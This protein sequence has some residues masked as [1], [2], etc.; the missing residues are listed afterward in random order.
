MGPA[1]RQV[2]IRQAGVGYNAGLQSQTDHTARGDGQRVQGRDRAC[3]LSSLPF[4]SAVRAFGSMRTRLR[5]WLLAPAR[6]RQRDRD[7]PDDGLL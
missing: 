7:F 2:L 6:E 3:M 5:E 4:H 1:A